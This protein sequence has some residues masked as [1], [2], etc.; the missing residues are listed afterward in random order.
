MITDDFVM[1]NFISFLFFVSLGNPTCPGINSV[2]FF[3][4]SSSLHGSYSGNVY[5]DFYELLIFL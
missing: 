4:S 2:L 5:I 3:G 1:F